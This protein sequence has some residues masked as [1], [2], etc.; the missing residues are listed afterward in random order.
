MLPT[1]QT[2]LALCVPGLMSLAACVAP[3]RTTGYSY[4]GSPDDASTQ[5]QTSTTNSAAPKDGS[6]AT[7]TTT[8]G[9][10]MKIQA[11]VDSD[12]C[13]STASSAAG[14]SVVASSCTGAGTWK[15]NGGFVI[16]DGNLCLDSAPVLDPNVA[17]QPMVA[18]CDASSLTQQWNF[19]GNTLRISGTERCLTWP[20]GSTGTAVGMTLADCAD[21]A[22]N[23]NNQWTL[24]Q[25]AGVAIVSLSN[26]NNCLRAVNEQT[27]SGAGVVLGDCNAGAPQLWQFSD[28]TIMLNGLC[29]DLVNTAPTNGNPMQ[30][31]TCNG[32]A[33]Q[34]WML[35]YGH[36]RLAALLECAEETVTTLGD[37]KVTVLDTCSSSAAQQFVIQ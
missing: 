8:T 28:N 12:F 32:G 11:M 24:G 16:L 30:L 1:K 13:L 25:Q 6:E 7:F 10:G 31:A 19:V 15:F 23:V 18:A 21:A 20:T 2:M 22:P 4:V 17:T 33:N 3:G 29:L 14:T 26:P 37:G 36:L 34:Q 9:A 27:N 35:R 5:P